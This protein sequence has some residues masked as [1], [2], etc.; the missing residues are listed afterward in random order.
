MF[1]YKFPS[2]NDYMIFNSNLP[3]DINNHFRWC[4]DILGYIPDKIGKKTI[5]FKN[6]DDLMHF[7]LVW[8]EFLHRYDTR[9]RVECPYP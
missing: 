6:E 3:D 8:D 1:H 4:R 2:L 5:S 9:N 7:C